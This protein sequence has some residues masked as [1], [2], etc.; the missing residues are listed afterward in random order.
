MSGFQKTIVVQG[1]GEQVQKGTKVFVH[2]TGKFLDGRIFDSSISRGQP[3]QFVVGAGQV[4]KGW[5]LGVEG[6]RKGEKCI[7]ICPPEYAYGERGVGP[8]PPNATLYFEVE[9]LGW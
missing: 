8:I 6:M 9:C 7:L 5:D 1:Y 3:F 4:I 2:Y